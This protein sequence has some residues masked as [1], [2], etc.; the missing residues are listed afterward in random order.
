MPWHTL[1]AQHISFLR[2]RILYI[3]G[4]KA[5]STILCIPVEVCCS[6]CMNVRDLIICLQP[7][8]FFMKYCSVCKLTSLL[9]SAIN[10][11]LINKPK[12]TELTPFFMLPIFKFKTWMYKL[13]EKNQQCINIM[14]SGC[15]EIWSVAHSK[16]FC[17]K[18]V[19]TSC[20]LMINNY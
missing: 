5:P 9:R 4:F 8:L 12:N 16:Y 11:L 2:I 18:S 13:V 20:Y 6:C 7:I 15:P 10:W 17:L 14:I 3:Y 1:R 19:E